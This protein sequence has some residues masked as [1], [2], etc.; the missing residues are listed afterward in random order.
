MSVC[1][2][3]KTFSSSEIASLPNWEAANYAGGSRSPLINIRSYRVKRSMWK[4]NPWP[5]SNI[6]TKKLRKRE[7]LSNKTGYQNMKVLEDLTA[8][9]V[10]FF[11]ILNTDS[12]PS[13]LTRQGTI[14][15]VWK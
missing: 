12:T 2:E 3:G 13:V 14:Y 4:T 5:V 6:E 1:F 7:T 8:P 15:Y 10:R 9:T 11:K